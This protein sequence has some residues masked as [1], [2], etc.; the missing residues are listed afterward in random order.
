MKRDAVL[1]YGMGFSYTACGVS[2][3]D[4]VL[5]NRTGY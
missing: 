2:K 4:G 3:L 1:V 5:K